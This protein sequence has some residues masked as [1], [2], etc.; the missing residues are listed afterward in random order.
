MA[1][2]QKAKQAPNI[3]KQVKANKPEALAN[4]KVNSQQ[5]L[6]APETLRSEDV[7]AAQ[8]QFG[9]QVVQRALDEKDRSRGITDKQGHLNEEISSSIQ[10]TRGSGASLPKDVQTEIG[11]KLGRDFGNVRLHTDSQA[12]KLSRTMNARAFTIGSDIFFKGG[13]YAPSTREGRETLIHELTHVVQQ[14][15]GNPSGGRLKLGAANTAMEQE[16]DSKGKQ[17]SQA[18]MS[19][20]AASVQREGGGDEEEVQTQRD[21][22][23]IVQTQE[24]EEEVQTQRDAA[25]MVQTQ[26]DEEE[27]QTQRD[28][29]GMVQTQE[30]EEEVQTQEDEE[31]VQTQRQAVGMV[32]TQEDEEEVQTQEDEEEVQTQRD[33]GG[34][35]Q[36]L[37]NPFEFLKKKIKGDP[38]ATPKPPKIK[39]AKVKKKIKARTKPLTEQAKKNMDA[40]KAK[41][42]TGGGKDMLT[43]LQEKRKARGLSE[44][45]SSESNVQHFE[46]FGELKEEQEHRTKRDISKGYDPNKMK[47]QNE[48]VRLMQVLRDP[49]SKEKDRQKAESQLREFH[50]EGRGKKNPATI[51]LKERKKALM[52]AGG[53]GDEGA[54]GKYKHENQSFMQKAGKFAG[55]AGALYGKHKD[56]IGSVMGMLGIGGKKEE[57]GA[58]GGGGGGGGGDG[59]LAVIISQLM[60]ENKNLREKLEAK[61]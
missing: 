53:K 38:N 61:K 46:K 5:I 34:V 8:Q 55:K 11:R 19:A 49:N 48:K 15:K 45:S 47:K 31:E 58:T 30:D 41:S 35:V 23:G 9:N 6:T 21:A 33:A 18:A 29:A 17:G 39:P 40:I 59:G 14:S 32:Q 37:G 13:V 51:A 42:Q 7:L 36:R 2:Y 27:V 4:R 3:Q 24:D 26:E 25:G 16:A 50:K 44:D 54:M 22:A 1:S 60:N 20:P 57:K 12:D 43:E 56:T 10:Q 52:E 28:A